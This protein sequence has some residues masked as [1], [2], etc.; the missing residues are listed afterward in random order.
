MSVGINQKKYYKQLR[1]EYSNCVFHRIGEDVYCVPISEG[2][3]I[4]EERILKAG[5]NLYIIRKLVLEKI[6]REIIGTSRIIIYPVN[7]FIDIRKNLLDS[8]PKFKENLSWM[9][10][11]PK[12]SVNVKIIHQDRKTAFWSCYRCISLL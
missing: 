12:I 3:T 1:K 2:K 7:S 8:I 6:L 11:Y 10:L 9:R 4:G 5:E